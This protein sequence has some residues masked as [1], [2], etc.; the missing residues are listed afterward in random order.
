MRHP[1]SRLPLQIS[2]RL[3]IWLAL[4]VPLAQ[5]AAAWHAL[6]HFGASAVERIDGHPA[7]AGPDHCDLCLTAA[8][9]SGGGLLASM[10]GPVRGSMGHILAAST[11]HGV[12]LA[13]PA[14]AYLSRAPPLAPR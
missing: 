7:S 9:V 6:S 14:R 12:W 13:P 1:R 4:L 2:L 8:S 3:L 11:Q 10:A 5:S